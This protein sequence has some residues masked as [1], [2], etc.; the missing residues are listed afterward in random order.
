[1]G[2][3]ILYVHHRAQVSGAARSLAALIAHLDNRWEAHVLAPS[4]PVAPLFESVGATV[5]TAPISLFQ[6]TWDNPYAGRKWLLLARE[7]AALVPHVAA[8][9]RL[10]RS[11]EFALVHLNDSPLLAAAATAH[12]HGLPVVWHLRSALSHRGATV[13]RLVRSALER[14]GSAAIAIDDDV[15]SSY[16]LRIPTEIVFNSIDAPSVVEPTAV[17]KERLALPVDKVTVGFIGNLRRVKGWPQLVEAASLLRD[18][19][20]HFVVLG[21]GVRSPSFFRTPYGRA[22][23][24]LGLATDDESDLRR[25]VTA[26][27]LTDRFTFLPFTDH[28]AGIY[29]ALDIVTFPNQGTGLGRPVLEAAAFG[30]PVVAAGSP[31]G[32]GIL[33]PDRSGILLPHATPQAL[34]GA[35][36]GLVDDDERRLELGDNAR[37]HALT[38]FDAAHAA[39]RV[40]ALYETLVTPGGAVRVE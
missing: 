32:A 16:R 37:R 20:V 19:Q 28:V 30:K 4:G 14:W 7:A 39:A 3:P 21:G 10:L 24:M 1:M 34:A 29:P 26:G 25:A 5:T 17:A 18:Q 6:H 11:R 36:R 35:I 8:M 13:P 33:L 27:R 12:R 2:V 38:A 9:E 23:S 40:S 15:A 22:A 31:T